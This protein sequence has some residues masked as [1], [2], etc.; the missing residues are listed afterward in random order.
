MYLK[1]TVQSGT[2]VQVQNEI[3]DLLM[4]DITDVSTCVYGTATL[5]GTGPTAG[6]YTRTTDATTTHLKLI[7]K[8]AQWNAVT[9]P[10]TM[11]LRVGNNV[12]YA[13]LQ[14]SDQNGGNS[15]YTT[16]P[17]STSLLQFAPNLETVG[18]TYHFIIN[19]TTFAMNVLEADS[20]NPSTDNLGGTIWSDF[21]V[22]SYDEYAIGVNP[23]Y[24]PG[25]AVSHICSYPLQTYTPSASTYNMHHAYRFQYQVTDDGSFRNAGFPTSYSAPNG[26]FG[27]NR[28]KTTTSYLSTLPA[29]HKRLFKTWSAQGKS[30]MMQPLLISP[31]HGNYTAAQGENTNMGVDARMHN[32]MLN[33]YR[34]T[35]MTGVTGD[36]F[37]TSD[38]TRYYIFGGHRSGTPGISISS[39]QYTN[40][41]THY[42]TNYAMPV[43]NVTMP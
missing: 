17:A 1:Y 2:N 18:T 16:Y 30:I 41:G 20:G 15:A 13:V 11:E 22:T 42:M 14:V 32:V 4:G 12:G 34:I 19:D 6:T 33:T 29:P 37:D 43:N 25:G 36:Y 5:A 24:Y 40:M 7:K 35:D 8:H 21:E 27:F 31:D 9:M 39:Q 23:L 26:Y 10:A 3:G 38:N 28:N